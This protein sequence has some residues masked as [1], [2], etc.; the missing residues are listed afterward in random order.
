MGWA[1][2]APTV[3]RLSLRAKDQ[4]RRGLVRE[5]RAHESVISDVAQSDAA[6]LRCEG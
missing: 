6:R 2:A 5:A 4:I 3:P 1:P